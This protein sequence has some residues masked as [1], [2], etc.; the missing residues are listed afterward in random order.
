MYKKFIDVEID[1]KSSAE[2]RAKFYKKME[3][4]RE[5]M[6]HNQLPPP[7]LKRIKTIEEKRQNLKKSEVHMPTTLSHSQVAKVKKTRGPTQCLNIHTR[8]LEDREEITLDH[9]G[10][11][12]GPT[13]EAVCNLSKFLGTVARY[14]DLCPLIYTNW[15]AL[16]DKEAI[17]EY[18]SVRTSEFLLLSA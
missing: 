12:I 16:K 6:P 3:V 10:E 14:S 4:K 11:A 17:W 5:N 15:K 13:N 9:E 2:L 1:S 18:V 8:L 7:P